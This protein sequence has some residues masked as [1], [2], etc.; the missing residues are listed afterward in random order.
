MP[1]EHWAYKQ[2]SKE[3]FLAWAHRIGPETVEQVERLF[4]GK[5]F[6]EQAFRSIKGVQHLA[7]RYGPERLELAAKR[8]NTFKLRGYRTLKSILKNHY[9]Q[10]P[11]GE[12]EPAVKPIHHDN[13]RGQDYYK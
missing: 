6:E 13:L 9:E 7:T 1:P 12:P 10:L 2:Q 4:E 8:A 11:L 3:R 5:R